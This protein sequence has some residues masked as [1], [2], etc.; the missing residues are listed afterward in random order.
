M[1]HWEVTVIKMCP[2][3]NIPSRKISQLRVVMLYQTVSPLLG[4]G[5]TLAPTHQAGTGQAMLVA[6]TTFYRS[7]YRSKANRFPI[8]GNLCWNKDFDE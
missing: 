6:H 8:T 2:C 5:F 3:N 1:W 4:N 7:Y